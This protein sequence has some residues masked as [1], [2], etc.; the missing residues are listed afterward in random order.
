MLHLLFLIALCMHPA[1]QANVT[2][3]HELIP[4]YLQDIS[5]NQDEKTLL[6]P[7]IIQNPDGCYMDI[8]TGGDT[9][10]IVLQNISHEH[11]TTL[12][13]SD[14]DQ[15]VLDAIPMRHPEI[16]PY[17]KK[18]NAQSNVCV[19]LLAMN[20]T[21]MSALED[22]SLNGISASA[23]IHEIFSY[24]S[25]K[26]PLKKFI[27]EVSRTLKP[28]GIF[29][30]RDPQW[31]DEPEKRVT[32]T[33][34][35]NMSKYF[36]TLFLPR[37]LDR[38]FSRMSL[39]NQC[40][41][42]NIYNLKQLRISVYLKCG[43]LAHL[44]YA[45]FLACQTTS[46]DF[47]QDI[48]I[49]APHGL[50]AEI[51]RHYVLFLR[52]SFPLHLIDE[53]V[54]NQSFVSLDAVHRQALSTFKHALIKHNIP[55]TYNVV[56]HKHL[57]SLLDHS[58]QFG[59]FI[60]NGIDVTITDPQKMNLFIEEMRA[61]GLEQSLLYLSNTTTLHIDPKALSLMYQNNADSLSVLLTKSKTWYPEKALSWM[62]REGEEFYYY[63]NTDDIISFVGKVSYV[64]LKNSAKDDYV[65]CPVSEQAL[66]V[67][68]R[69]LYT[70]I[71]NKD[72]H[73]MTPDNIV[74]APVTG[75]NIIHFCLM[76]KDDAIEIYR[77]IINKEPYRF[78]QLK[79]WVEDELQ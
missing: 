33:L 70:H 7:Y 42:P 58:V 38:T 53:E 48:R 19:Q 37:F 57:K 8:G 45:E 40:I 63:K 68:P 5:Y 18:D 41:K 9:L 60:E 24:C 46:I 11:R 13:A 1:M 74:C 35:N 10:A 61:K 67:A 54:L 64:N 27:C 16:A 43:A 47:N 6:I 20:A 52:D 59:D 73:I 32:L 77:N 55:V 65:L 2:H 39:D 72:M 56:E 31:V 4:E 26:N 12:I 69:Y 36:F 50:I 76:K 25:S 78:K 3:K 28:H 51:Q 79:K 17:L 30:Y 21:D 15:S 22:S 62:Q 75:K 71:L 23:L 44:N 14:L 34:K 66:H 29:I 49:A